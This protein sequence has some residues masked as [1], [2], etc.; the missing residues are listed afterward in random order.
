MQSLSYSNQIL[1]AIIDST[2]SY[3]LV[4]LPSVLCHVCNLVSACGPE[5]IIIIGLDEVNRR[6]KL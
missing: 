4:A 5:H 1:K 6:Q 2:D 3:S